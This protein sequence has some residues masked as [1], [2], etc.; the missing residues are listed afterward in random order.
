M[1]VTTTPAPKTRSTVDSSMF[2]R[3]RLAKLSA[4]PSWGVAEVR[5][6]ESQVRESRLARLAR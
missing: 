4:V 2:L 3:T 6:S 1:A 5:M